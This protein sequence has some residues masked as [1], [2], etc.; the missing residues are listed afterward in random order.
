MKS[1]SESHARN[2]SHEAWIPLIEV[3]ACEVFELMVGCRLTV[4]A[5]TE[6]SPLEITSMVGLAGQLCGVLSVR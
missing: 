1:A 3:A 6:E 2:G 4:P 5:S